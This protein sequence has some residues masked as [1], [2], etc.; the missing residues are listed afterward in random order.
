MTRDRGWFFLHHPITSFTAPTSDLRPP[1]VVPSKTSKGTAPPY[2]GGHG[3][4]SIDARDESPSPSRTRRPRRLLPAVPPL[5]GVRRRCHRRR[6]RPGARVR[7]SAGVD[8]AVVV[9]DGGGSPSAPPHPASS[10]RVRQRRRR[11]APR[12]DDDVVV[13]GGGRA[14]PH[15][16]PHPPT[17]ARIVRGGIRPIPPPIP[18]SVLPDKRSRDLRGPV[19]RFVAIRPEFPHGDRIDVLD[20][21]GTDVLLHVPTAGGGVREPFSGGDGGEE[22]VGAGLV[23]M[24][25]EGGHVP[26]VPG[27]GEKVRACVL[28]RVPG[29]RVSFDGRRRGGGGGPS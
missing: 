21:R 20:T 8:F 23:G 15:P 4:V 27:G 16:V 1:P 25:G 2:C 12:D 14:A 26:D 11:A 22:P 29:R 3:T 28:V 18:R 24:P 13:R 5:R 17:V 10:R 7:A 19:R 6:H 9:A